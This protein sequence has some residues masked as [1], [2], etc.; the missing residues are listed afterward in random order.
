MKRLLEKNLNN[1]SLYELKKFYDFSKEW[2]NEIKH[3]A[4]GFKIDEIDE[5]RV[6]FSIDVNEGKSYRKLFDV[7]GII[8][9]NMPLFL[10]KIIGWSGCDF[11]C[12]WL[13]GDE[14]EVDGYQYVSFLIW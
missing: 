8:C 13:F 7:E 12:S 4:K 3:F 6:V 10:A 5:D 9:E 1:L 11:G 14:E 2:E